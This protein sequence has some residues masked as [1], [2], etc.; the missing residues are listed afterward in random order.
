VSEEIELLKLVCQRLEKAGVAYMLTGSLAA[1]FY[2]VPRMTRDIDIVIEIGQFD[3][4]K[5]CRHFENDFY[6]TRSS[7]VEAVEHESI[8]NII[9]NVSVFK[10]DFIIRKDSSYRDTEFQRRNQ[11]ELD[12]M[13]IWIVSPEDLIISKLF[14]AKDSLSELQ[15]R[16]V[17]NLQASIKKL[18]EKYIDHWVQK[19]K[20]N[21]IYERVKN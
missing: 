20:L 21:A 6:L 10:V 8:F 12:G 11:I 13:Q 1:N 5:F 7:I 16:D 19:L 18:D 9:H 3:I 14:W 2:A 17:K 4:G 15:L